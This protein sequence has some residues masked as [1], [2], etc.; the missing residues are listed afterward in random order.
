M[1]KSKSRAT[2]DDPVEELE[3]NDPNDEAP[4]VDPAILGKKKG[5]KSKAKDTAVEQAQPPKK[6][7]KTAAAEEEE[8][9]P[10]SEAEADDPV[11]IDW[12]AVH[13]WVAE[14]RSG[15]RR[16]PNPAELAEA[17]GFDDAV[18]KKVHKKV[19][20][21]ADAK[22]RK[23]KGK[24][25]RGYAN[26]AKECGYAWTPEA[27]KNGEPVA[28]IGAIDSGLDVMHPLVSMADTA[29]L[30]TFSPA[31]P[32]AVSVSP[33][34]FSDHMEIVQTTL[35]QGV[36]REITANVDP[37]FRQ[38]MNAAVKL[39][40]ANGGTRLQPATM[41]Q[42][43]KPMVD[44]LSFSSVLAP[45]GL[46][47]FSKDDQPPQRKD[48]DA[49]E[50]GLEAWKK[51]VKKFNKETKPNDR[52]IGAVDVDPADDAEKKRA[53]EDA[54]DAKANKAAWDKKQ[55]AIKEE[56]AA[57]KAQKKPVAA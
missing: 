6:K 20:D 50:K 21:M 49:G 27:D 54:E 48:F 19:K 30:V 53:K 46:V 31:T 32:D 26:L 42:V 25:I 17:T 33:Q 11:E 12:D 45:P 18:A 29:R 57:K 55:V 37:M 35:A 56:K 22:V 5:K 9:E 36:A 1:G 44:Q 16:L 4:E 51:E 14:F 7:K 2:S 52:G 28:R 13:S 15:N 47:K 40:I 8:E 24:K 41:M 23:K 10:V 3:E 34:E 38:C 43:L 39:Q